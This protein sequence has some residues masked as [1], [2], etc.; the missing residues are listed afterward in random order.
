MTLDLHRLGFTHQTNIDFSDVAIR[1]MEAKYKDLN[2][3]W[4]VMDVRQMDGLLDKSFEYAID[5]ATMD[6][7]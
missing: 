6:S 7:M 4:K 3:V 1:A 2:T 5:K